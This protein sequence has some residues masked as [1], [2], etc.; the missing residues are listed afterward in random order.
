MPRGTVQGISRGNCPRKMLRVQLS[1]GMSRG[2]I[3]GI[4]SGTGNVWGKC[5]WGIIWGKCP[6][7]DCLGE[8]PGKVNT[9]IHTH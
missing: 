2:N 1:M 3:C 8:C 9:H 6:H 5:P 7:G 4:F